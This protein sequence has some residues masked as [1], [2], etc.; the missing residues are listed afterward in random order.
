MPPA[1]KLTFILLLISFLWHILWPLDLSLVGLPDILSGILLGTKIIFM[2]NLLN[3][4]LPYCTLS[5]D[6]KG[7]DMRAQ[8]ATRNNKHNDLIVTIILH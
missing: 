4:F 8:V 3:K 6:P 7:H 5:H 1:L 2:L